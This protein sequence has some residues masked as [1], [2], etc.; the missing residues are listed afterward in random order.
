[1]ME[2]GKED[3]EMDMELKYGLMVR[4]TMETGKK[5]RL[6]ARAH[7]H[8]LTEILTRVIGQMIRQMD[9]A[10]TVILMEQHMKETG[11]M[12]YKKEK[13]WNDGMTDLY[14]MATM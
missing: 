8:M 7:L 12:I 4:S 2:S 5:E 11:L 14:T 6:M 1:M 9:L 3:S 13:V 10:G